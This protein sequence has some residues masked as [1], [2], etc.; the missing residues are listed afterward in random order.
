MFSFL[1]SKDQDSLV[2]I[3]PSVEESLEYDLIM[4]IPSRQ[5]FRGRVNSSTSL[6]VDI[7]E[8][9]VLYLKQYIEILNTGSY[10]TVV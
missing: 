6:N 5:L 8:S 1:T 10:T 3:Y 2:M 7:Q 4:L 9:L